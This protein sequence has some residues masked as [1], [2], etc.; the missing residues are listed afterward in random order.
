MPRREPA[1]GCGSCRSTTNS[2]KTCGARWRAWATPAGA[3]GGGRH[4]APAVLTFHALLAAQ[5]LIHR[6]DRPVLVHLSLVV[7]RHDDP[8]AQL[9]DDDVGLLRADRIV[10]AHGEDQDGRAAPG[11][12]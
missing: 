7:H 5:E 4:G 3:T 2:W 8:R 12:P 10:A 11:L 6:T 1:N 9:A